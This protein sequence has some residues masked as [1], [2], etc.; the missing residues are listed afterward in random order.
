MDIIASI[1]L[2]IANTKKIITPVYINRFIL[3]FNSDGAYISINSRIISIPIKIRIR[4]TSNPVS[5]DITRKMIVS[6][7]IINTIF[8]E[9][10]RRELSHVSLT[11]TGGLGNFADAPFLSVCDPNIPTVVYARVTAAMI[12][13]IIAEHIEQNKIIEEWVLGQFSDDTKKMLDAIPVIQYLDFF[14]AQNYRVSRRC[15]LIDPANLDEFLLEG[16]FFALSKALNRMTPKEVADLVEV[17]R[18]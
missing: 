16:G 5:S 1:T 3:T 12:P 17:S 18:L 4:K 9:L 8:T 2:F 11:I 10:R 13:R 6:K 14:R 15:G 7:S